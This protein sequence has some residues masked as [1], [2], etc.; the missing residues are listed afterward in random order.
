MINGSFAGLF[1]H[2]WLVA[3]IG[4]EGKKALLPA[5]AGL[6]VAL[7]FLLLPGRSGAG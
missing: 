4:A 3:S 6:A 7:W 2:R 5:A 1:R